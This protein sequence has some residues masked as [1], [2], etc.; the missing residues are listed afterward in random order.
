M[1][2]AFWILQGLLGLAFLAAGIMKA[3]QPLENLSTRMDWV[4]QVP[5]GLVRFIGIAE[6][7]GAIGLIV[8]AVTGIA[9]I[10]TPIAA[11]ALAVVMLL[12]AGFHYNRKEYNR[13]A[14]S[15]VLFV[16]TVV[17]AVGRFAIRPF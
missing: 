6:V 11:S 14:P 3:T 13:I 16:L 8:P 17:V 4:K 5:A 12:A 9:S 2:T 1:N 7:L 15:A 10:L